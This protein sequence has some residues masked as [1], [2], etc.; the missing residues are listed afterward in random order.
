[1]SAELKKKARS[2]YRR[3]KK[4]HPDARIELNFANPLELFVATVLSAQCTDVRVN[5]VTAELFE[6]YKTPGDYLKVPAEEL[7]NDIRSTGFFRNKTKSIRG[8]AQAIQ[9]RFGGKVPDNLEDLVTLP[10]AGRKTANVILGNAFDTPGIAVDTHVSRIT[11]RL[12][13]TANKDPVKIEFDLMELIHK[14][15]WTQ[16]SHVIIFHGRRICKARK[17]ACEQC[18]LTDSCDF[19]ASNS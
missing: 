5:L 13:L 3:L 8:A 9:E 15:E 12:G 11:R 4:Q 10:G 2:V 14:K 6:K 18:P 1:M 19:Y 7:E 16:F 17:P